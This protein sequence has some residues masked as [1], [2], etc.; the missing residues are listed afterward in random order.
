MRDRKHPRDGMTGDGAPTRRAA[1]LVSRPGVQPD[2]RK[3]YVTLLHRRYNSSERA[4][5]R[6]VYAWCS[7]PEGPEKTTRSKTQTRPLLKGA[8][9]GRGF[10]HP[11]GGKASPIRPHEL[12]GRLDAQYSDER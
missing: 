1:F 8:P 3:A 12:A 6:Q 9:R 2:L 11:N 7:D 4:C 10:T 5:E